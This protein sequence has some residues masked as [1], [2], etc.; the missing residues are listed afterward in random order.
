MFAYYNIRMTNYQKSKLRHHFNKWGIVYS[1]VTFCLI[2]VL[3]IG[4]EARQEQKIEELEKY[5]EPT[6]SF[7]DIA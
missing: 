6:K 4:W 5:H 7:K 2:C 3:A 1:L